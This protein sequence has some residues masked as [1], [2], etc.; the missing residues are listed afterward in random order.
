MDDLADA[1]L[2]FV[3][4][5]LALGIAHLLHDH[6]LGV[7]RG[8]AAEIDGRQRLGDIVADGGGGVAAIGFDEADFGGVVLDFLDHQQQAVQPGLAGLGVDLG[9]DFILRA[10]ARLRGALDRLLHRLQDD[11][12]V[13]RFLARHRVGDLQKF[14]PVGAHCCSAIVFAPRHTEIVSSSIS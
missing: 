4:H 3:I 5:A 10:I 8:D 7:L 13:D 14:E 12:L 6:L 11:R 1:V 2:E 9:A